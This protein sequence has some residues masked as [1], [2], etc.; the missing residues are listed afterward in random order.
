MIHPS[1]IILTMRGEF[2]QGVTGRNDDSISVPYGE[3]ASPVWSRPTEIVPL[4]AATHHGESPRNSKTT[5]S[6][7]R[8]GDSDDEK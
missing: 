7:S 6:Y 8:R 3:S 2:G 4:R 1:P 5:L